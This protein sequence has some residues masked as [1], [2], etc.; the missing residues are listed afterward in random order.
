MFAVICRKSSKMTEF[1]TEVARGDESWC[2][3]YDPES[4]QRSSQWKSPNS[5]RPKKARQVCSSVKDNVDFFSFFFY[6]DGQVHKEF[7]PHGQTVNRQFYLNVLR[8]LRESMLRKRPE[9]WQSG[10]WF[11]HNDSAAAH[12]A[13][14]V[15]QFLAKNTMVVV[16]PPPPRLSRPRSLRF[17]LFRG[18]LNNFFSNSGN[19]CVPLVYID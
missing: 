17:F 14:S 11:L 6:V 7:V 16:C 12:T 8:R 13:F 3:G 18:I 19:F 2:Y 4:K 9:K 1:R 15:Q 10:V 5:P